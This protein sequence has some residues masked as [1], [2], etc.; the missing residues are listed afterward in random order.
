MLPKAIYETLPYLYL[1]VSLSL[2]AGHADWIVLVFAWILYTGAAITWVLRSDA[3]RVNPRRPKESKELLLHDDIY[4]SLPFFYLGGGVL[5]M[6]F[7]GEGI[8]FYAGL[9]LFALGIYV[10]GIRII[11]RK[12]SWI[13]D[14][15]RYR[16]SATA[17]KAIHRKKMTSQICGH[18]LIRENCRANGLSDKSNIR[19]MGWLASEHDR[20]AVV[21]L[22]WEIDEIEFSPVSEILLENVLLKNKQYFKHCLVLTN[23]RKMQGAGG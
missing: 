17:A 6:R 8:F 3:R 15:R 22:R 2:L 19:I 18:C 11:K 5:V 7:I 16:G 12:I 13:D 1:L 23:R 10:L 9:M 14:W 20:E 4:E 21:K